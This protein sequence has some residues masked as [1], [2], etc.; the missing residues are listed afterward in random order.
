MTFGKRVRN[1]KHFPPN[2]RI[3]VVPLV[4]ASTLLLHGGY[5]L[6]SYAQAASD[7]SAATHPE[8]TAVAS[9][10]PALPG[11]AAVP[12]QT[13]PQTQIVNATALTGNTNLSVAPGQTLAINFGSQS[14]LNL[15]GNITN[16]GTIYAFSSNPAVTTATFA[17]TNITNAQGALLSTM[18]PAGGLAGITSAVSNLNLSLVAVNN[19]INQGSIMSAGNLSMMA[20]GS[21]TNA[22]P[23]GITGPSPIMQAMN[24]LNMQAS[25]ITNSGLMAATTGNINILATLNSTLASSTVASTLAAIQNNNV[26]INNTNGVMQALNGVINVRDLAY[27]GKTDIAFNGG[28]VLSPNL[29]IYSGTGN[30]H[31]NTNHISGLVSGAAG[32]LQ[33]GTLSGKLSLGDWQL[34]GDPLIYGLG[35]VFVPTINTPNEALTIVAGGSIFIS[36]GTYNVNKLF[37]QA[38]SNFTPNF[39]GMGNLTSLT[40]NNGRS[41]TGGNIAEIGG[42]PTTFNVY[43]SGAYAPF[44]TPTGSAP[45][46][47]QNVAVCTNC[48]GNYSVFVNANN[49]TV[50]GLPNGPTG[51][52][53]LPNTD[54]V[55]GNGQVSFYASG[56]VVTNPNGANDHGFLTVGNITNYGPG[57][58]IRGNLVRGTA[59]ILP[60]GQ[61]TDNSLAA[62]DITQNFSPV[63]IQT[64]N[65]YSAGFMN[66]LT[67]GSNNTGILGLGP[68]GT[69]IGFC[70]NCANAGPDYGAGAGNGRPFSLIAGYS[71]PFVIP[72][73]DPGPPVIAYFTQQPSPQPNP[74][75]VVFPTLPTLPPI[76]PPGPGPGPGPGGNPGAQ[77]GTTPGTTTQQPPRRLEPIRITLDPRTNQQLLPP[78]TLPTDETPYYRPKYWWDSSD[79]SHS[80]DGLEQWVANDDGSETHLTKLQDDDG[81]W[82]WKDD[83]GQEWKPPE[84]LLLAYSD[85][86]DVIEDGKKMKF[87][88]KAT[89][90][91]NV[92][93]I[94]TKKDGYYDIRPKEPGFDIGHSPSDPSGQRDVP[95]T[96]RA[97]AETGWSPETSDTGGGGGGGGLGVRM[98][99]TPQLGEVNKPLDKYGDDAKLASVPDKG[100]KLPGTTSTF[101][102]PKTVFAGP[103]G[104]WYKKADGSIGY[105]TGEGSTPPELNDPNIQQIKI[106]NK[107][108]LPALGNKQ[109]P[110]QPAAESLSNQS[111]GQKPLT[112]NAEDMEILPTKMA[113]DKSE[114]VAIPGP[115]VH[116]ADAS[117]KQEDDPVA[118]P[119]KPEATENHA[120]PNKPF[121]FSTNQTGLIGGTDSGYKPTSDYPAARY[122]NSTVTDFSQPIF[123]SVPIQLNN[124]TNDQGTIALEI[125]RPGNWGGRDYPVAPSYPGAPQTY[126]EI[127]IDSGFSDT[128]GHGSFHVSS[129]TD[130]AG[131]IIPTNQTFAYGMRLVLKPA[132]RVKQESQE[133]SALIISKETA[134]Y[135][136][137]NGTKVKIPKGSVVYLKSNTDTLAVFCLETSEPSGVAVSLGNGVTV[138]L[139][140]GRELLLTNE[141][142]ASFERITP[143]GIG[144]KKPIGKAIGSQKLF[145]AEF[146][147]P[148]A[149]SAIA[150][151]R[152]MIKQDRH[153][154]LIDGML[155]NAI[156]LADIGK[157]DGPYHQS[158]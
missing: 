145:L 64:G 44:G 133:K 16:N 60:T 68:A 57:V 2:S 79:T 127:H 78:T 153:R 141:Q 99:N 156:V 116:R 152:Q 20:G 33:I 42:G 102:P 115:V 113:D 18:L 45:V 131:N 40:I 7:P 87:D 43:A 26:L 51:N 154:K 25:T 146:S 98:G 41:V 104:T 47:G 59:Q 31:V 112:G 24:N 36:P 17:A 157:A 147:I 103:D 71:V 61:M 129:A 15:T 117:R 158:K 55:V 49:L 84:K 23:Q 21:I 96:H 76:G 126:T 148:G 77:P 149:I 82:H 118:P 13:T 22:L 8:P 1:S 128:S 138:N 37:M 95:I 143:K 9:A 19:I 52:I 4:M 81:S 30:I 54:F 80:S 6:P 69:S 121:Q 3:K 93:S 92:D 94:K 106:Q 155:K 65:V 5:A 135:F 11:M 130:K 39:D 83:N 101:W 110:K 100:T 14:T 140:A 27:I 72:P 151:L 28:D 63:N 144:F 134:S 108:E 34:T 105:Y 50:G 150:P 123:R 124:T 119:A 125:K 56:G 109:A 89:K 62:I 58:T 67:N 88:L 73:M 85:D 70:G 66:L 122:L 12:V 48:N 91:E 120:H 46:V 136:D 38:G 142:A 107:A 74:P 97:S 139:T 32:A 111:S 132:T 137:L 53:N 75:S 114:P 29:N 86:V 35:D 90:D 10:T